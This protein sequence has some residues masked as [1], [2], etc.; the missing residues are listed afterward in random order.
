MG[1]AAE[2]RFLADQDWD[3]KAFLERYTETFTSN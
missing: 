3:P 1:C 2:Q